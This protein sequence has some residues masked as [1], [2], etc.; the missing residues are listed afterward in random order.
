M[1]LCFFGVF[2][3]VVSLLP[4]PVS[5]GGRA[6]VGPAGPPAARPRRL[7][8]GSSGR[9]GTRGA[10]TAGPGRQ[11]NRGE[12]GN[13]A[14]E[15]AGGGVGAASVASMGLRRG[16][17]ISAPHKQLGAAAHLPGGW[18]RRAPGM[19]AVGSPGRESRAVCPGKKIMFAF[20]KRNKR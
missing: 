8:P 12:R 13:S 7:N 10:G 3:V 16:G 19:W 5:S 14:Q 17:C 6:R 11:E 20:L 4:L 15:G 18:G 2:S 9:E 1:F